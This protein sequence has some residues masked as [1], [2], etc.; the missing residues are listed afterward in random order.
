VA[1]AGPIFREV[2][3]AL[4]RSRRPEPFAVP[5]GLKRATVCSASGQTPGPYCQGTLREWLPHPNREQCEM[6]RSSGPV[7][8]HDYANWAQPQGLAVEAGLHIQCPQ[9]GDTFVIDPRLDRRYQTLPLQAS[10]GPV[11]WRVDGHSVAPDWPLEPGPHRIQAQAPDGT[12][13]AI[14]ITVR[15]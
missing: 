15:P 11:S 12:T 9:D 4:H 6:H 10:G 2:M 3:L 8:G 1:G 13:R 14:Q 7:Y 5:R